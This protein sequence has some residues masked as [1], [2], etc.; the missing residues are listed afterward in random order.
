MSDPILSNKQIVL[1]LR[2]ETVMDSACV[3]VRKHRAMRQNPRHGL[4]VW[5]GAETTGFN[6]WS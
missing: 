4:K 6:S 2:Q 1:T 3:G 5:H